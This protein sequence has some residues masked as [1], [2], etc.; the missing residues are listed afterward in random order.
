MLPLSRHQRCWAGTGGGGARLRQRAGR[1]LR[2]CCLSCFSEAGTLHA[3][4]RASRAC[5]C[6]RWTLSGSTLGRGS[7]CCGPGS[8]QG[9]CCCWYLDALGTH[10]SLH[11]GGFCY[12]GCCGIGC[13][14]C[15]RGCGSSLVLLPSLM[16]LL[17]ARRLRANLLTCRL[18]QLSG[19]L[20]PSLRERS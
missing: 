5:F 7:C 4:P 3:S 13:C 11:R 8:S 20:L 16:L 6:C 15:W 12:Y 18:L 19:C 14:L 17:R 10:C 2:R 1:V 9:V